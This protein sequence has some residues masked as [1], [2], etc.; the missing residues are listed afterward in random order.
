MIGKL[1]LTIGW[2]G[3]EDDNRQFVN[4][5]SSELAEHTVSVHVINLQ[6][7]FFNNATRRE[8]LRFH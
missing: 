2:V 1:K 4:L 3:L 6:D 8:D 5:C 7:L